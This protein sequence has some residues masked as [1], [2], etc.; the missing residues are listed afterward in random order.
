[1]DLEEF[2]LFVEKLK[3]DYLTNKEN[4]ENSSIDLYLDAIAAYSRDIQGL[5]NNKNQKFEVKKIDWKVFADI[6]K[7]AKIYE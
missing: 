3:K 2:V 4:W 5:Y 7:G 6:L 1:M